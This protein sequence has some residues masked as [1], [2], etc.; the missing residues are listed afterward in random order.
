[1]IYQKEMVNYFN[2]VSKCQKQVYLP[3]IFWKQSIEIINKLYE[4]KG[5]Y[6]FRAE[7]LFLSLFVP[8]YGYPGNGFSKDRWEMLMS[9]AQSLESN[10]EKMLLKN[11][12]N[13][14][15][16]AIADYRTFLSGYIPDDNMNLLNFSES[17]IGNPIEQFEFDQKIYSRS[18]LNYLLGLT[19]L[20]KTMPSFSP[21]KVLEIGGGFGS[22]GEIIG[23]SK[24]NDMKYI[25]FDLPV[26]FLI[27]YD[28]LAKIFQD[29]IFIPS[30]QNLDGHAWDTADL[31]T[32]SCLPNWEIERITGEVDLFVNFISFQEMEPSIVNNYAKQI[33]RLKPKVLL[34]RNLREGKQVK[35]NNLMGVKKPILKDDYL[36]FF[37]NY[38]LVNSNVVPFGYQTLDGFHSELLILERK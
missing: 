32:F 26:M 21:R 2:K 18:S 13:G 14:Y 9:I 28:Y 35:R 36:K 1:M 5:I 15:S 22:L 38:S 30:P 12:L 19:F 7:E 4:Q 31:P 25:N 37:Q 3:G 10:K 23:K 17:K 29:Q 6:R 20:K 8:T 24:L 16:Q 34:L 27:S 33:S 11:A